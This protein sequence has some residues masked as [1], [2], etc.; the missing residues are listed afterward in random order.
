MKLL[1]RNLQD[2]RQTLFDVS[3]LL[4]ALHKKFPGKFE[5]AEEDPAINLYW[6]SKAQ[7]S[8]NLN[9]DIAISINHFIDGYIT[10]MENM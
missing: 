3:I 8:A 5:I 9:N 2:C 1:I 4:N 10:A 6:T 7:A